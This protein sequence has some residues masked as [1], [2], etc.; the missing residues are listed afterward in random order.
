MWNSKSWQSLPKWK[1]LIAY[2]DKDRFQIYT[3]R[4]KM[5][6]GIMKRQSWNKYQDVKKHL[7]ET[8]LPVEII[9]DYVF[10]A[11]S[12]HLKEHITDY[13]KDFSEWDKLYEHQKIGVTWAVEDYKGVCLFADDMGMGKTLQATATAV[14][15]LSLIHISEPTR[16][17]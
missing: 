7:L 17:Y 8:K 9:P 6:N 14:I 10:K 4:I 11:K 5:P 1:Y 2:Q 3:N 15:L 12:F 13:S 16:P